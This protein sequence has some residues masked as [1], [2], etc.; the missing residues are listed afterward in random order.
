MRNTAL[1]IVDIG[2]YTKNFPIALFVN[3]RLCFEKVQ[4]I[5]RQRRKVPLSFSSR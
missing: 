3:K 1:N 2:N 5:R 4:T